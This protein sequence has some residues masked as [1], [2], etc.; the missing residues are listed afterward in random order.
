MHLFSDAGKRE[1]YH[2]G[3]RHDQS[4]LR[5][6]VHPKQRIQKRAQPT[7]MHP[8]QCYNAAYMFVSAR[9]C[10]AVTN[11]SNPLCQTCPQSLLTQVLLHHSTFT[12]CSAHAD[13]SM[14]VLMMSTAYSCCNQKCSRRIS[15]K[16][17]ANIQSVDI[18]SVLCARVQEA[19]C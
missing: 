17:C 6:M 8:I 13:A 1:V 5:V 19:C 9:C 12:S 7:V 16:P 4:T 18:C 14:S 10:C 15:C 3:R 2:R 11:F